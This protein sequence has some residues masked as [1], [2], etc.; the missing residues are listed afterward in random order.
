MKA[1]AAGALALLFSCGVARSVSAE[2][3][4]QGSENGLEPLRVG[5]ERLERTFATRESGLFLDPIAKPDEVATITAFFAQA[6]EPDFEAFSGKHPFE[7]LAS[8]DEHGDEGN[9]A[10]I[11]SVGIAARLIVLRETGAPADQVALARDAAVRAAKAWH[12]YGAIGGPGV[13]ARGVRRVVPLEGETGT[14]P[15]EL[16]ELVPLAD[17]AG[18]PLPAEKGAVWRAPVAPGFEDWIWFDDTSKDQV[19]GYALAAAWLWDALHDDPEV[20]PQVAQD[21]A[22]DL[23]AFARALMVVAPEKGI[24]LCLRDADGRLTS[25]HDLNPREITPDG[26]P[27]PA[28]NPFRNGFN[29]LLA[30]GIVR[31]AYHV[32]GDEEIGRYYYEELIGRR[33]MAADPTT[34]VALMYLG[35]KTNYSNVNMA[36]IGLASLGR[37]ETDGYV[38][39]KLATTLDTQFWD[40]GSDRDAKTVAQPW[41]DA[42]Y[43]AYSASAPADVP[44]RVAGVL[45]GFPP[46]PCV[47]R[48]VINCDEGEL[49]QKT[50]VAV[51]GVTTLHILDGTGHNGQPVSAEVVPI[52][53][54]PDSDFVWRSDPH[55]VNGNASTKLDPRGDW[56]AAYWLARASELADPPANRSPFARPALPYELG[57][58]DGGGGAG[59]GDDDGPQPADL[60]SSCGCRLD[61][62]ASSAEVWSLAVGLALLA[63]LRS[64]RRARRDK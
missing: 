26:D 11:A 12:V 18:N 35:A 7:A 59:A 48:D 22:D 33:N 36:A 52:A 25:F 41:F 13:V 54:R 19:S 63:P 15:G 61:R 57:P 39:E 37:F 20:D 4:L 45:A 1:L 49:A 55:S 42:V 27:L 2:P 30:L 53:A 10:G 28:D 38:L 8:Y 29:A 64:R 47:E 23:A 16:P 9:F 3:I 6:A 21:L 32:T 44:A 14:L 5:Y 50:C 46:A 17:G 62:S 58:G 43:G 56:L 31:A 51:D 40:V 60:D 34:T 24:D